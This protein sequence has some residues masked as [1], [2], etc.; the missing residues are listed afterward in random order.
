MATSPPVHEL[1]LSASDASPLSSFARNAAAVR[2]SK[3]IA[4]GQPQSPGG[5]GGIGSPPASPSPLGHSASSSPLLAT[6]PSGSTRTGAVSNLTSSLTGMTATSSSTST[7]PPAAAQPPQTPEVS[8]R[9]LLL[10]IRGK[11]LDP[12][13]TIIQSII[14]S[15]YGT[16]HVCVR[17]Y[18]KRSSHRRSR[19]LDQSSNKTDIQ[20][21]HRMW[22]S[23][24]TIEYQPMPVGS[25]PFEANRPNVISGSMPEVPSP[26]SAQLTRSLMKLR[27]SANAADAATTSSGSSASL[28]QPDGT[29]S[30]STST[31]TSSTS[32]AAAVSPQSPNS[33]EGSDSIEGSLDDDS[34][35]NFEL[36][37]VGKDDGQVVEDLMHLLR[38][39]FEYNTQRQSISEANKAPESG[40]PATEG[41]R[42]ITMLDIIPPEPVS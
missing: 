6:P 5:L 12:S 13:A 26:W 29:T 41:V 4:A 3:R 23:V 24:H 15:F 7:P 31:S 35:G 25:A 33:L 37:A 14:R 8:N 19:R 22:E 9:K 28:Q 30:T 1:S 40:S 27:D 38:V 16:W 21:T 39:L 11:P 10:S 2:R 42:H 18:Q 17:I 36:E 20:S 32:A 34:G